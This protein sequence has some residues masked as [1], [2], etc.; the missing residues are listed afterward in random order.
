MADHLVTG[1][2]HPAERA[3]DGVLG[4]RAISL[5]LRRKDIRPVSRD[6]SQ[7][8][9]NENGLRGERDLM[10]DAHFHL[11]SRHKPNLLLEIELRP[12]RLTQFAGPCE[13]MRQE[14][15]GESGYRRAMVLI[16]CPEERAEARGI[17]DSGARLRDGRGDRS[18]EMRRRVHLRA[19]R[20]DGITKDPAGEGSDALRRLQF[21]L[22]FQPLERR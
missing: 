7:L 15:K 13:H 18:P 17:D 9:E 3:V 4:E 1:E 19:G 12:L 10:F 11:T 20:R 6:K 5:A 21:P 8:F 14:R 16:D 22:T 2:A